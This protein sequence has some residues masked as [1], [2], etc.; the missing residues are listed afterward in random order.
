MID[1]E[2]KRID[3]SFCFFSIGDITTKENMLVDLLLSLFNYN[4]YGIDNIIDNYNTLEP[5]SII[6]KV[7]GYGI[8][9]I[10]IDIKTGF[11]IN[12]EKAKKLANEFLELSKKYEVKITC[13]ITSLNLS[14]G[15]SFGKNLETIEI[16]NLLDGK[17]YS[18]LLKL[19]IKI[20][21]FI[22]DKDLSLEKNQALII[23][24]IKKQRESLAFS[25]K[26]DVDNLDLK[27]RVFS[28]KSSE[29][30]FV[31][32]IDVFEIEDLLNKLGAD[33][34]Q[35]G[36]VFS[37]QIGDYVLENEELAKVYLDEKDI[38][39]SEVL[40]CFQIALEMGKVDSLVKEIVR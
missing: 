1:N 4:Y 19:A 21:S 31:K 2:V 24:C 16:A 10:V 38:L 6:N 9:N 27:G 37:K 14:L 32:N 28:I 26:L 25:K 33:N 13:F 18:P 39:A 20:T 22:I 36:I 23:E 15:T 3:N 29:T 17:E 11:R 34:K 12:D 30:G 5:L 7:I 35:T 8:K 40:D